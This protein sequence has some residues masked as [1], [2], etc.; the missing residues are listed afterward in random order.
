MERK[1]PPNVGQHGEESSKTKL[2]YGKA[3]LE[4]RDLSKMSRVR[5]AG[6][7]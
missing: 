3:V 4:L 2:V 1:L 5:V 7:F 6:V